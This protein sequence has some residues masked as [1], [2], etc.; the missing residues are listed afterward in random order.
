MYITLHALTRFFSRL[1]LQKN[2]FSVQPTMEWQWAMRCIGKR[3]KTSLKQC[4]S[5][6]KY[7]CI[8]PTK[9]SSP[10]Y[11]FIFPLFHSFFYSSATLLIQ[12][13]FHLISHACFF[14]PLSF[15]FLSSFSFATAI[16]N[17]AH[18]Q[19]NIT[20]AQKKFRIFTP[21]AHRISPSYLLLNIIFILYTFVISFSSHDATI[22]FFPNDFP[23]FLSGAFIMSCCGTGS[24]H[25]NNPV[26]T[27]KPYT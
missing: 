27:K 3:R 22:C 13:F 18:Q 19:S 7:V 14:L 1:I 2:S 25:A 9:P 23:T 11:F 16:N 20:R 12:V 26:T 4:I 15:P 17:T 5:N 6:A 24:P 10:L 21:P 8:Q